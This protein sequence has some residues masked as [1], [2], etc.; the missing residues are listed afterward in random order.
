VIDSDEFVLRAEAIAKES[1]RIWDN[2]LA[3]II[4]FWVGPPIA[5]PARNRR[6]ITALTDV[7]DDYLRYYITRYYRDRETA[8]VLQ[9]VA[10][11]PDPAVDAV[12][13]AYESVAPEDL[14]KV[15]IAHRLSMQAENIVGKL[16]ERYIARFLEPKGWV[17]CAGE[18]LR[19]VD[20][21]K[22]EDT[23]D[24]KLLQVKNRSNSENSSSSAIRAQTT[25]KKWYR[26]SSTSGRTRWELLPEND[27]TCTETGF[28]EFMKD[29]AK[30]KLRLEEIPLE[31][32]AAEEDALVN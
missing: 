15:C 7:D 3:R 21:M 25:I 10:T 22:D 31:E 27:G 19:S 24:V 28:Y 17:W 2:R 29:E 26:I 6:I 20:F 32:A 1:G 18:T 23:S 16:L 8:I 12:L 11:L 5:F 14:E 4:R 30:R 13:K 9:P